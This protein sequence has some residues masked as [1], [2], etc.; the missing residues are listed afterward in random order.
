[1]HRMWKREMERLSWR[2]LGVDVHLL[3]GGD[4]QREH[5]F[6]RDFSVHELQRRSLQSS[7]GGG[8]CFLRRGEGWQLCRS[9]S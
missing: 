1:M 5:G 3:R 6:Q 2:R 7:W 9:N 4:V 8:V